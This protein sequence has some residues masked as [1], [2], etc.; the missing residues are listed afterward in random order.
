MRETQSLQTSLGKRH[1][2]MR[3]AV[4]FMVKLKRSMNKKHLRVEAS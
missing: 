2:R 4:V 3:V 1:E